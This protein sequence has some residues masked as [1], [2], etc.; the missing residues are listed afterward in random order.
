MGLLL[1]QCHRLLLTFFAPVVSSDKP[2]LSSD[3]A[4][5][6]VHA[7]SPCD[8]L[9]LL[10]TSPHFGSAMCSKKRHRNHCVASSC[11]GCCLPFLCPSSA[12]PGSA[13]NVRRRVYMLPVRAICSASC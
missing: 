7:S 2:R 4:V 9:G 12:I 8:L 13:P 10:H 3:C 6:C 11:A 5:T 1:L